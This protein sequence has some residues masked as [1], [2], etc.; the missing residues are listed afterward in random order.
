[1]I[2]VDAR[3]SKGMLAKPDLS[4]SA[5]INHLILVIL[6]FHFELIHVPGTMHGL[7]GLSRR[8]PQ[9]SDKAE[10]DANDDWIDELYGF[11]HMIN[12]PQPRPWLQILVAT[13]AVEV[14]D[15]NLPSEETSPAS[16]ADVPR[17]LQAKAEDKRVAKVRLWLDLLVRPS[18]IS[19]SDYALFIRYAMKFF[20]R[21]GNLWR[22]D[23]Y[24]RHQLVA[25][26]VSQ[27]R[28]LVAAHDDIA[29][30][31]FYATNTLISK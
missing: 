4:L 1:M 9:P 11:M 22:K 28:I 6:T 29:H 21:N 23:P 25:T 16:Y 19:D 13:F 27:Y 12:S 24:V 17:I 14:A 7:D 20:L 15:I 18:D 26:P 8:P 2:E 31:G 3:Y 5:G 30:K 10:P